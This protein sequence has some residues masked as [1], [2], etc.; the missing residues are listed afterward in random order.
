MNKLKYFLCALVFASLT[1]I[2]PV[3]VAADNA[4]LFEET[5]AYASELFEMMLLLL[6]DY[7]GVELTPELLYEAAMR[8]ISEELDL[9]SDYLS[10]DQF[11]QFISGLSGHFDGIGVQIG[12]NADD[13]IYIHSVIP[14]TPAEEAGI[15]KGDRIVSINGIDAFGMTQQQAADTIRN[16]LPEIVLEALRGE[17]MITFT[18]IK[19]HIMLNPI[20]VM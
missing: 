8:G 16:A 13:V 6:D 19:R 4:A 5:Q 3:A 11:R 12:I 9:F 18:M 2:Q 20:E 15:L 17:D 10:K 7:V 14:N 1:V